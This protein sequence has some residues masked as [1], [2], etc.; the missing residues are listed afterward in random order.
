MNKIVFHSNRIYNN[1][2]EKFNPIPTKNSIPTWYTSASKYEIDEN[3]GD[4]LLKYDGGRLPTFKACP[5]LLDIFTSGYMYVTPC[6]LTFS[7][8]DG[9]PFVEVEQGFEDFCAERPDM[10]NFEIPYGH[11]KKHFHWY[12][13]WAPK[14]PK[15]YSAIYTHP[16]NRFD[17]PFTTVAGIIDNDK[18]DTPGLMPF[19][20]KDNFEGIIPAGTPFIQ[21]IPFK[22]ED[23]EMEIKLHDHEEIYDRHMYQAKIYR[24]K[25]GGAY[26]QKTWSKK[27]YL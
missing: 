22:R 12:P 3:S 26:K 14:L 23:W 10:K 17:L 2:S 24:T 6:N 15:G 7:L 13:N 1:Y 11:Y 27:K 4:P 8:K 25:D 16:M 19:F 21:I 9:Q 5:A 18:M 20:L